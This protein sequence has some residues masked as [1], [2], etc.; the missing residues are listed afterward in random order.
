MAPL[1]SAP[2]RS[3]TMS[4]GFFIKLQ[5]R[6]HS[7]SDPR[8]FPIQPVRMLNAFPPLGSASLGRFTLLEAPVASSSPTPGNTIIKAGAELQQ[9]N[10]F[11]SFAPSARDS[12]RGV[13][14]PIFQRAAN[15]HVAMSAEFLGSSNIVALWASTPLTDR[16]PRLFAMGFGLVLSYQVIVFEL[17]RPRAPSQGVLG[18][19]RHR[20]IPPY[21]VVALCEPLIRNIPGFMPIRLCNGPHPYPLSIAHFF[22]P[23]RSFC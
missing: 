11:S 7:D 5:T 6:H 10:H 9:P 15:H 21:S 16:L 23:T 14:S 12:H 2:R 17:S 8:P 19:C 3:V 4:Q 22:S 1:L 20:L 13:V 18:H